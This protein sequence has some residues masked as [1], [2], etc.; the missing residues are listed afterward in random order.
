MTYAKNAFTRATDGIHDGTFA[1]GIM[2]LLS[3]TVLAV[4]ASYLIFR[5][6]HHGTARLL[7]EHKVMA[8]TTA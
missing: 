6:R 4:A 2:V 3:V 5:A 7:D 1:G 8:A